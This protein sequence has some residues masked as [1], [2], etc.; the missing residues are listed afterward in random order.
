MKEKPDKVLILGDTNSGLLAIIC[1]R[2][3][4]PIGSVGFVIDKF[5]EE[6][7]DVEV[8]K[9]NGEKRSKSDCF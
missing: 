4:I 7:Y 1:E 9:K 5:G 2:H 3:K 6:I 8:C